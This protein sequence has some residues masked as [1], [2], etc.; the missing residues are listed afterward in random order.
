MGRALPG[1]PASV[2]VAGHHRRVPLRRPVRRRLRVRPGGGSA[3][4]AATPASRGPPGR[5]DRAGGTP[6]RWCG[7]G[8]GARRRTAGEHADGMT[9]WMARAVTAGASPQVGVRSTRTLPVLALHPS[10]SRRPPRRCRP[11]RGGARS[12]RSAVPPGVPRCGRRPSARASLILLVMTAAASHEAPSV[13][14]GG[15]H[16]VGTDEPQQPGLG[17]GQELAQAVGRRSAGVVHEEA[18]PPPARR[19]RRA[20]VGS[21]DPRRRSVSDGAEAEQHRQETPSRS[22]L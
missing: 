10:S 9:T 22:A 6:G 3:P 4:G 7:A 8:E 15:D 14:V 16:R 1:P 20:T 11:V 21:G 2:W 5:P 12:S 17:E 18:E 13:D 19:L